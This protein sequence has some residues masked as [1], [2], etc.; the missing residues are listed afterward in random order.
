[1]E[2]LIPIQTKSLVFIPFALVDKNKPYGM[3]KGGQKM[4]MEIFVQIKS[5]GTG[6]DENLRRFYSGKFSVYHRT[7]HLHSDRWNW[8]FWPNRKCPRSDLHCVRL[9]TIRVVNVV[10][11]TIYCDFCR[12]LETEVHWMRLKREV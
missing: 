11:G 8:K 4:R 5:V 7:F 2:R 12:F 3:A 1:M 6:K 10:V 9:K